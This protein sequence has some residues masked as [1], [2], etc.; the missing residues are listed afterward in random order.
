[1]RTQQSSRSTLVLLSCWDRDRAAPR[2]GA[3]RRRS[4]GWDRTPGR[5]DRPSPCVSANRQWSA[6]GDVEDNRSRSFFKALK[7]QTKAASCSCRRQVRYLKFCQRH[8]APA[9][10]TTALSVLTFPAQMV[11]DLLPHHSLLT[12]TQRTRK[13][14]EGTHVQVVLQEST[15]VRIRAVEASRRADP[16]PGEPSHRDLLQAH[17]LLAAVG[18][19]ATVDLQ[20]HDL[21]LAADVFED[22]AA[23]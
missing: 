23:V 4:S 8:L 20:R 9:E 1:M 13:L 7:V 15:Q 10:L 22:L 6:Q 21:P 3:G 2:S 12:F 11:G 5:L 19:T 17:L 14:K 16:E 18:L